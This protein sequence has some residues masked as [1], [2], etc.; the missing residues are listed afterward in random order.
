MFSL[1][2]MHLAVG[3]KNG[4][5]TFAARAFYHLQPGRFGECTAVGTLAMVLRAVARAQ[6]L[7]QA[8]GFGHFVG[9]LYICQSVALPSLFFCNL[10][11]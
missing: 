3:Q 8:L 6:R 4:G 2:Y 10:F 11:T 5:A 9:R 7:P 1:H